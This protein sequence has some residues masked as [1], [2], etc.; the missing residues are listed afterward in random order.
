MTA[1]GSTVLF[2]SWHFYLDHSNGASVSTRSIL[3]E[4]ARREWDV[5]ALCAFTQDFSEAKT[6]AE[7][8]KSVGARVRTRT[9]VGAYT[10]T[11]FQ[12]GGIRSLVIEPS[13][14]R[15]IPTPQDVSFFMKAFQE[16]L[17]HVRPRLVLTYGGHGVGE[18][19]LRECRSQGI[20]TVVLLHNLAYNSRSYFNNVDLVCVPSQFAADHYRRKLSIS[21]SVVPPLIDLASV[22]EESF[23]KSESEREYV[24]FFNPEIGKGLGYFI[25]IA[26]AVWERRQDVKFLL[27]EGRYGRRALYSLGKD[28]LRNVGNIDFVAN[29]PRVSRLFERAKI[30]LF[31]SLFQE[32]FGR[33]AA[34]SLNVGVPVVVS[35]R[36]ALPETARDGGCVLSIPEKYQPDFGPIPTDAEVEPWVDA[37]LRLWDDDAFYRETQ[38][39]GWAQATR[40]R[41]D[42][43]ADEYENLFIKLTH[44]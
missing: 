9:S 40:W 4:L 14:R 17:A 30:T 41:Y 6:L 12:D 18:S 34:E 5:C 27:V 25:G 43:V 32:T 35:D 44:D 10:T 38:R 7:T 11:S 1:N 21:S 2:A 24:L 31:P 42:A 19:I 36:G 37:L 39:K 22:D 28:A 8:L 29:T 13:Q 3:L 16:T 23:S 20:K 15:R 33:V 26:R